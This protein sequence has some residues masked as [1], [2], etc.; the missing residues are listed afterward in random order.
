MGY[1]YACMHESSHP[2]GLDI[3]WVSVQSS[4]PQAKYSFKLSTLIGSVNSFPSKSDSRIAP[5]PIT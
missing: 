2:V 4:I 3:L 5:F 1:M